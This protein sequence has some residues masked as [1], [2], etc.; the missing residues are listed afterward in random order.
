MSGDRCAGFSLRL[1]HLKLPSFVAHFEEVAE[2]ARSEDAT[3]EQYL[4]ELVT[5]ELSEREVRKIER[6]R[7]CSGLPAEKTLANLDQKRLPAKVRRLLPRRSARAAS[8][9]EPRTCWPSG[10][11]GAASLT[12]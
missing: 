3:F 4:S 7:K 11:R 12:R 8:P 5:L 9:S 10:C 2:K 1:R 6:L